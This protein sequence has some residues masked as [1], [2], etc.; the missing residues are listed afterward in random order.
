MG[1]VGSSFHCGRL[2]SNALGVLEIWP[3]DPREQILSR[4]ILSSFSD[5]TRETMGTR[6]PNWTAP[7]G[8][9]QHSSNQSHQPRVFT[10]GSEWDPPLITLLS[11]RQGVGKNSV[12]IKLG[13]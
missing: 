3:T 10:Q 9:V 8:Q 13:E 1:N 6:Y 12:G 5:S 4:H 7:T 2:Y 11:I